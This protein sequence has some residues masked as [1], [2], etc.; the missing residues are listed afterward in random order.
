[1]KSKVNKVEN[2]SFFSVRI[3]ERISNA[4]LAR[5]MREITP[6]LGR[7][8]DNIKRGVRN[9]NRLVQKEGVQ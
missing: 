8:V 3:Y 7:S 1:M 9:A 4:D 6:T 5:I 2:S